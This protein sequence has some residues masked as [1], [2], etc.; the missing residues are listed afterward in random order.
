VILTHY[1]CICN[2]VLITLKMATRVAETRQRLLCNIITF[3]HLST[4][5]GR[6]K[7]IY[8]YDKRTEHGTY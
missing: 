5:V 4:N 7:K 2:L 3:I 6:F 1:N 8:T